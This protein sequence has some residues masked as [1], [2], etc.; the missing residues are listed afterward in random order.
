MCLDPL[1]RPRLP[2]R[3]LPYSEIQRLN[4][5]FVDN[6]YPFFGVQVIRIIGGS[7]GYRAYNFGVGPR[8]RPGVSHDVSAR[9]RNGRFVRFVVRSNRVRSTARSK[10]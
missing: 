2:Q 5:L 3:A 4:P 7:F 6:L 9:I 1:F 10:T 8:V